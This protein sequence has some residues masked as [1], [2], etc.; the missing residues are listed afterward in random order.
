MSS[1]TVTF[2]DQ[3]GKTKLMV[4]MRFES[5]AIRDALLK[6]GMTAGWSQSLERLAECVASV[7]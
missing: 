3:G 5:T 7:Q 2:E 4:R 6:I 1:Q